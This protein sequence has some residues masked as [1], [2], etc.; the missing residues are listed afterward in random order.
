MSIPRL[1]IERPITMFM[2]SGVIILIGLLALMRLP[3]DL[4]P[5]I[6]FPSITV[7][8]GYPGVGPLEMEELVTRPLEQAL[9]AVAGLERIESTSS[10]GSTRVTLNFAWGTD[11]NEAAD[12]V[13]NRLDRVRARFPEEAEAPIMFKFDANT[14]PIMGVGVEGDFDRV[15]LREIAEHDLSQRLER[16]PGVA[17]VTVDGGLRRQIHVLLSKEKI[18]ALD[19]PVDRV[20][21]LLRTENQNI[22]LGEIDEGDRTYL[23]RSQGQFENLGEIRDLVVLTQNGVPVYMKDI[24]EVKDSTEDFRSFTRINGRPGVRLRITKQSGTNTVQIADGV[25]A[26]IARINQQIP[27]IQLTTLDDSS[28]FI[29]RA[30]NSVKEHALVGGFLVML[31]IFLFLRDIRATFIVFTSIPISVIGTF[32]LLYF[33]G[34]TLNTMTFGGLAL[35]IGM[36]VD[37]S[38][39]VLENTSRHMEHGKD[40]MQ[41]A[42]DG[43]E[44]VWSAILASTL[45]HIAVFVPLL[46]LTGVSSILFKQLSVV[47]MFSLT[48]SLFVAVTIVPVLC[49]RLLKLPP[50]AE[51]RRGFTGRLYTLSE[52]FL[53]GMDE[54]YSRVIRLALHHRPTV[55]GVGAAAVVAAVLILP[56][57]GFELM[58]QADEGEVRVTAELP[59]GTR[60]E[61]SEE[62]AVRLEG[63][64][65]E[66]VPEA[67]DVITNAGGGGFMGGGSN[68]V[69]VQLRLVTRDKRE[70]SSET[71]ARDLNRQLPGIIP[72]VIIQTRASGGN[73][74]FQRITGGGD[75][76]RLALEI[77]GDDLQQA[78]QLAQSAKTIMDRVP[79]VRNARVGRDDGR[80]ELAI[81]VDRPK[82]ALLGL[83]VTGV[84][85]SIRTSVGGTQAAFFR[86]SGNE[87]P[88]VVRLREEDRERVEDLND[89]LIGTPQGKVLQAKNLLTLRNQSGPTEIERKNQERI[90]RVTAEPE[91]T[92]SEALSAVNARLG[93]V[94][95]PADFS[96]GFGAEAEEQAR[97]FAQLRL[98]LIL[99][100]ILV[101]AVMASQYE[102]LRDPFI[103]MFS[104]PLAAIGVVLALKLTGT[105]FSLQ[106]YIGIIMLAG[107][108]VSN[109]ILLV[110]YTNILR[111][112]DGIPL[113]EAV[114][115]AGRVRLRPILMTS[116]ATM[117]GLVPMAMGIGEGAELQAPLARV[118]IGGLLASTMITLVVVPTVY[119]LFEEGWKGLRPG[120]AKH[121]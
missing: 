96:M 80:P 43:S 114:E 109:A 84:A 102:S 110:D 14:F 5:D 108:V 22:P 2:L 49:S 50:A 118:V 4:M 107:I 75:G 66:Y 67:E 44:E 1:A 20:V 52:R 89:L 63:L 113:R 57:I 76:S 21:N 36:I 121:A 23:V 79:E 62:V 100:I 72:G 6:S 94:R 29:S 30:I 12:D 32:A 85:N 68:R 38:I 33:N 61:R 90:I 31:I 115:T 42:I 59:V 39:V 28:V 98:M 71:I 104:V 17:S 83:S 26:E 34:Y 119:T 111:R 65:K 48:M 117:L 11:L 53:N 19:L 25:R 77:R 40:R 10:E 92:L 16:V 95:V 56:T 55:I 69:Q 103:I 64:A 54:R 41:A 81:Q 47:V 9:S 87:Y 70:R 7:R 46:F 93:E 35:G 45:T 74:Q 58:P 112:R 3:V 15:R 120:A 86:E 37:A 91:A 82:A 13:R 18:R 73:Q 106:A 24:A 78:Q 88:I 27:G 99:A 51:E 8:V 97:A 105:S 60:I 116:L 101:Y